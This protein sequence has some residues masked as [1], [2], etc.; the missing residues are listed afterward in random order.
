MVSSIQK[1][2]R[3]GRILLNSRAVILQQCGQC[4]RIGRMEGRLIREETTRSKRISCKGQDVPVEALLRLARSPVL[5]SA[6]YIC[7]FICVYV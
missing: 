1:G 7:I 5:A 6:G 4:R 3:G 2:D